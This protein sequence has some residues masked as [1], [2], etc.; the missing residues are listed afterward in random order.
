MRRELPPAPA[1]DVDSHAEDPALVLDAFQEVLGVGDSAVVV[2]GRV[3]VMFPDGTDLEPI[4]AR[5]AEVVAKIPAKRP[6][7]VD[8]IDRLESALAGA[9]TLAGLRSALL[10]YAAETKAARKKSLIGSDGA[11]SVIGELLS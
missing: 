10:T 8:P 3:R 5:L 4:R 9:S 2:D 6:P 1:V 11:P 7:V